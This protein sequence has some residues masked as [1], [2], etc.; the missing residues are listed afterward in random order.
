MK[1]DI[2]GASFNL[3]DDGVRVGKGTRIGI[4]AY[5]KSINLCPECGIKIFDYIERL[6]DIERTKGE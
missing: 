3:F 2:C 4:D 1:C 5:V 6:K